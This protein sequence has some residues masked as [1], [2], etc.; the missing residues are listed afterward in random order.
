MVAVSKNELF[1]S[2]TGVK[3]NGHYCWDMLPSQQMLGAIIATFITIRL[4]AVV[5]ATVQNPHSFLLCSHLITVW[6]KANL[7]C[8]RCMC[9]D[10]VGDYNYTRGGRRGNKVKIKW[11]YVL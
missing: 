9:A 11:R 3:V 4:S 5:Q 6:M 1:L 8:V 10:Y 7:I 2:S